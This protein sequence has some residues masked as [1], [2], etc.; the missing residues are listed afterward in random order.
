MSFLSNST[1]VSARHTQDKPLAIADIS[2]SPFDP[3]RLFDIFDVAYKLHEKKLGVE[4]DKRVRAMGYSNLVDL[5]TCADEMQEVV[6]QILGD[7]H[8]GR[9]LSAV[10]ARIREVTSAY[11]DVVA[12]IARRNEAL[13]EMVENTDISLGGMEDGMLY[14][15]VDLVLADADSCDECQE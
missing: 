9:D 12:K 6:D 5:L 11:E 8:E 4:K 13:D 14:V 15:P 7:Y 2:F 10:S 3:D 1:K